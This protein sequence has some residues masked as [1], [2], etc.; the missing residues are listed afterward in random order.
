MM[1]SLSDHQLSA[2]I[3]VARILNPAGSD[4]ASLELSLPLVISQGEHRAEDLRVGLALLV[5]AELAFAGA[6]GVRG[7][8]EL[9]AL[10]ALDDASA[11]RELRRL[12]QVKEQQSDR[13][14]LGSAGE[15]AVVAACRAELLVVG[16][17][18]LQ[19][20]II[21]VSLFDDTL[22]YDIAAPTLRGTARRL[23]VKTTSQVSGGV[24][25]FYLSR[26]EYDV[27][28]RNPSEWALVAC[29]RRGEL[30][31]IVGW[32]RASALAPYLPQDHRGRWTEAL[33]RVPCSM[34]IEGTPSCV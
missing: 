16:R 26:N 17:P 21:Q 32:C 14:L 30:I 25:Q 1:N 4:A 31:D 3:R 33:V 6:A 18:D 15:A 10:V 34:L 8:S 19:A 2:A 7:T 5:D 23:E 11:L 20:E 9:S 24:F 12:L 27:G 22:G 29:E 13:A 28:C